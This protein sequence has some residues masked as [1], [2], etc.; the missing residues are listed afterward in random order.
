MSEAPSITPGPDTLLAGAAHFQVDELPAY[1]F[2]GEGEH[3]Y[4]HIEKEGMTTDAVAQVLG[5]TCGV[6]HRAI[7]FAGRKDRHGITRQWFSLHFADPARLAALD[8]R[9]DRGGRLAVLATT[10]HRNKIRLGHLAGN[11][12]KLGCRLGDPAATAAALSRLAS[13]GISNRFGPQR[14]GLAGSSLRLAQAWGRG[15]IAAAVAICLDPKGG[16]QPGD[17]VPEGYRYPPEGG[18]VAAMR[19]NP[20]DLAGALR[21]GGPDLRKL[22]ASAAQAA[23]FN[24]VLDARA[25]AGL[26]HRLR[27]GDLACASNGA[28]FTV[29][30][31]DLEDVNRRAQPGNLDVRAT[32]P[33]PGT[34]RLGPS[35]E[36]GAEERAWSAATGIDWAWF[37][38][39]ACF[40]SPGERRPLLQRFI[41]PPTVTVDGDHAWLSFALPPGCYATEVLHQ[42]G[43]AVPEDRRGK[44]A[45]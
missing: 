41:E 28:P 43:V 45:N 16:W 23:V 27:V 39:G 18:V 35:A 36:V 32:G 11:R 6:A 33:L 38:E 13:D 12:F 25:A 8:G 17:A 15:D 20:A 26:T 9:V 5:R 4:V 21:G 3:L 29:V 30:E 19:R 7:G 10:R 14:F 42:I 1:P 40:E 34:W 22:A 2:S 37:A 31:A 24:A 44:L